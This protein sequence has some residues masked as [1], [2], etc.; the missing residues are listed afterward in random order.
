MRLDYLLSV[1]AF[2]ALT[3]SRSLQHVG[4]S[5][6]FLPK[7]KREPISRPRSSSPVLPTTGGLRHRSAKSDSKWPLD[8][9]LSRQLTLVKQNLG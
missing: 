3:A 5:P 6:D 7:H 9:Q 4:K 1:L 8:L 2:A